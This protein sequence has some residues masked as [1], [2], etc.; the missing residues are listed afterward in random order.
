MAMTWNGA[1]VDALK[2]L[3]ADGLTA[4]EIAGRLGGVTRNAVIGK[5]HRLGLSGRAG[6]SRRKLQR[7][8]APA[9]AGEHVKQAR[10]A[11]GHTAFRRLV[12]AAPQPGLP[13]AGELV[14]PLAERKYVHTLTA[15]CCRW[16]IGD[17]KQPAFHFCGKARIA[18]LPYCRVHA[19]RAFQLPREQRHKHEPPA[20]EALARPGQPLAVAD[21][22]GGAP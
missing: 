6:P 20:M 11:I 18:G 8:R 15:S 3:W 17:P 22:D 19:L 5:V 21:L 4:N 12:A 7:P 9:H 14:I 10:A 1:R 2:K 16:P 13:T